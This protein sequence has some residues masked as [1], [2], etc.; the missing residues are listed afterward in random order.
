MDEPLRKKHPAHEHAKGHDTIPHVHHHHPK[1]LSSELIE[2]SGTLRDK[3]LTLGTLIDHLEGRVYTLLLVLL[4][5]PFCQP[6]IIPG[7]STPFGGVIALLGLRFALRQKPWLPKRAL[8]MKLSAK[9][10]PSVMRGGAKILRFFEKFLHP[11]MVKLF[12]SPLTHLFAGLAIMIS[13]ILLA[14]PLPIPGTNIVPAIAIILTA[15]AFSERDG[16]CLVVAAAAFMLNLGFFI[17]IAYT[18]AYGGGAFAEWITQE[19]HMTH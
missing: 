9:F 7:L 11:R 2:L 10:L 14:L 5:L 18:V 8:R 16:Y 3:E 13:G 4:S 12:D 19:F 15:A 1:R 17:G 6:V